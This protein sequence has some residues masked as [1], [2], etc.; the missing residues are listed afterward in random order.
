MIEFPNVSSYYK[1]VIA[2][3]DVIANRAEIAYSNPR[4]ALAK[5]MAH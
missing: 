5:Q 4:I 2:F 3:P 1:V